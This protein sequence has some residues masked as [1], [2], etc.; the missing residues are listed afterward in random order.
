MRLLVEV[1]VVK[2]HGQ[3]E[4]ETHLVAEMWVAMI[5]HFGTGAPLLLLKYL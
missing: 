5:I 4:V 3:E 1:S 2:L